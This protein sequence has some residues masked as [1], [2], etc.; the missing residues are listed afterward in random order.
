MGVS[1]SELR[2]NGEGR[3]VL[4]P[5]GAV[6]K[7]ETVEETEVEVVLCRSPDGERTALLNRQRYSVEELTTFTGWRWT[8]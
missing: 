3:K 4:A 8:L 7:I 2:A 1:E 6:F 5:S